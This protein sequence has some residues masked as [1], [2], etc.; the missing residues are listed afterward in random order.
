MREIRLACSDHNADAGWKEITGHGQKKEFEVLGLGG[1]YDELVQ[2]CCQR[3][4]TMRPCTTAVVGAELSLNSIAFHRLSSDPPSG[5]KPDSVLVLVCLLQTSAVAPPQPVSRALSE[6]QARILRDLWEAGLAATPLYGFVD[7]ETALAQCELSGGAILVAVKESSIETQKVKLHN[8]AQSTA[9]DVAVKQLASV[10]AS[11]LDRG[12][13]LPVGQRAGRAPSSPG[14]DRQQFQA[15][16]I[17]PDSTGSG[18]SKKG[19]TLRVSSRK[20]GHAAQNIDRVLG[21]AMRQLFEAR[22]Q[23]EVRTVLASVN[24]GCASADEVPS[25]CFMGELRLSY[26][27]LSFTLAGRSDQ[28]CT[29]RVRFVSFIVATWSARRQVPARHRYCGLSS[30]HAAV[31]AVN[32]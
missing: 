13:K 7:R 29:R 25:S 32:S 5:A 12:V 14:P 4:R 20:S 8:L 28:T 17:L 2:D 18:L 27:S 23:I 3:W 31:P 15:T 1:R 21:P 26:G 9:L 16:V 19:G 6:L 24:C 10:V 30:G 22:N 11:E